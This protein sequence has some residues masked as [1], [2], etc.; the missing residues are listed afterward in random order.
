MRL[1]RN[2]TRFCILAILLLTS[3]AVAQTPVFQPIVPGVKF[4]RALA[5]DGR[6]YAGLDAGGV[7][8][9]DPEAGRYLRHLDRSQGLGGHLVRDLA[10][11][12]TRLLIAT[13]DGGITA[14]TGVGTGDEFAQLYS[15]G[16][17][18]LNVT[19]V[20]GQQV[21]SSERIYYGTEGD[22][23]G[24]IEGGREG[25][26][27]TTPQ[28]I[29][30]TIEHVALSD[31]VLLISTPSGLSRFA[32]N[33]FTNYPTSETG[34]PAVYDLDVSADGTIWLATEDGLYAW[35]DEAEQPVHRVGSRIYRSVSVDGDALVC[36]REFYSVVRVEDDVA[37]A[38]SI[39]DVN[40]S[41]D[42]DVRSA[43]LSDGVAWVGGS[44]RD[45]ADATA[46]VASRAWLARAG[47]A[48]ATIHEFAGSQLG[49]GGGY[50]GAAVDQHG[51]AW[52]GDRLADGVGG[53]DDDGWYH[54]LSVASEENGNRGL[55]DH[56]GD[57]LAMSRG[58]QW[59]WFSQYTNG[60]VGFAPPAEPGGAEQWLQLNKFNSPMQPDGIIALGGH[61]DGAVLVCSDVGNFWGGHAD[62]AN[63]GVDV[64]FDPD[65]PL[66]EDSWL[67]IPVDAL[68]G[69]NVIRAAAVQRRD[70]VWFAVDGVGLMRWDINGLGSGEDDPLTW[71]N[72]GDDRWDGPIRY[73]DGGSLDLATTTSLAFEAD[74]T[75]WA[76][77]AGLSRFIY[78]AGL[79]LAT[80]RSEFERMTDSFT[81]GLLSTSVK[82]LA[83]DRNQD[84]WVLTE[85][86]LNRFR[87]DPDDEDV[88][89]DAY[90][91]LV[92]YTSLDWSLYSPGAIAPLPGGTYRDLDVSADG[93]RLILT[94]DLGAV[95]LDV[96]E[97]QAVGGDDVQAAYV[98][99]NPF[100]GDDGAGHISL[101]GLNVD[102]DNPV[103]LEI[104]NLA[105]QIVYQNS[106]IEAPED[107]WDGRNRLGERVASG[108]Y[109]MKITQAGVVRTLPLAVTF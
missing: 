94:S 13:A 99:P 34:W 46:S 25:A 26:Y 58:G 88:D 86:G 51:R 96:P 79:E 47:S 53:L 43:V 84:L 12:G 97:R 7:V 15:T 2:C 1:N 45:V 40:E 95:M 105:G 93:T 73:L 37:S 98:Y 5:V 56:S 23:I 72:T 32:N 103:R 90:T 70:V 76:G 31:G 65:D 81:P 38:L 61:P 16:L 60:I 11:S 19:C 3:V 27:Y 68:G 49:I 22:G 10:W 21:G 50:H 107:L 30:D 41:L 78:S 48:D 104:L 36:V 80:F 17:A 89:V 77:G 85:A 20:T 66:N 102:D 35:D 62:N 52:V 59:I 71:L 108:M 29:D 9:F 39:P 44:L 4:T 55:L 18:S 63:L 109:I 91:D 69:G 6:I 14:I 64:L 42:L 67:H 28:L 57:I 101:G 8:E 33:V 106:R 83:F 92:T 75:I 82:G 74:G 24:V 54:V 87:L 100:P